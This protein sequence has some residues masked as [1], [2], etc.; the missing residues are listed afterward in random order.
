MTNLLFKAIGWI[1]IIVI[2]VTLPLIPLFLL[3]EYCNK[4]S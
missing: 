4:K 1:F 3:L 2:C